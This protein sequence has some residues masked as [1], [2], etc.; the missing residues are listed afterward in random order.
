MNIDLRNKQFITF[1]QK[2]MGK[3][4]FNAYLM[5]NTPS[6]Y[7][8]FDPLDEHTDN[9]A[10]DLVVVPKN[11]RGKPAKR[12]L[13][14]FLEIVQENRRE[15]NYV[16]IDEVNRYH[17]KGGK[18][19]GALGELVDFSAHWDTGMGVG[20]IARRPVQVH[21]DIRELSDYMFIFRLPGQRDRKM[22]NHMSKG[23]GDTVAEL[24]QYEY[25]IYT[26]GGDYY[27]Q[28]PVDVGAVTHRK[29]I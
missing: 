21:T 22:L 17:D 4:M 18:L 11:K 8:C 16:W 19:T 15:F 26:P 10:N 23:L 5:N 12:E 24:E 2:D 7:A 3:S 13:E 1:G 28:E 20:F 29:G 9:K 14:Q 6:N 27:K 25:V